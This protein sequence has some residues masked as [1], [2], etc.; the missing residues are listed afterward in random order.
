[1]CVCMPEYMNGK[2]ERVVLRFVY[3]F[4]YMSPPRQHCIFS[5]VQC[6]AFIQHIHVHKYLKSPYKDSKTNLTISAANECYATAEPNPK[7]ILINQKEKI[8]IIGT[9]HVF[10]LAKLSDIPV[11]SHLPSSA[12]QHWLD[13]SPCLM[14]CL[15]A[16]L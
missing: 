16:L 12:S 10:I 3:E 7:L 13:G 5:K 2:K 1:M 15:R 4:H 11:L 9:S 6:S 8:I 14:S